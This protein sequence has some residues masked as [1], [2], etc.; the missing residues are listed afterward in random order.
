MITSLLTNRVADCYFWGHP[1]TIWDTRN[2][3]VYHHFPALK[4]PI[5]AIPILGTLKDHHCCLHIPWNASI[6]IPVYP[7]DIPI[8]SLHSGCSHYELQAHYIMFN[9]NPIPWCAHSADLRFMSGDKWSQKQRKNLRLGPERRMVV[10]NQRGWSWIATLQ[11]APP[12]KSKKWVCSG[13]SILEFTCLKKC[14]EKVDVPFFCWTIFSPVQWLWNHQS[15]YLTKAYP[16]GDAGHGLLVWMVNWSTR[17]TE[18]TRN[19]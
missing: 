19:S 3:M 11:P 12:K 1:L 9:P 16:W 8:P 5:V 17:P 13:T 15:N 6:I 14:W 2:P 10:K 7:H 4:L 18:F